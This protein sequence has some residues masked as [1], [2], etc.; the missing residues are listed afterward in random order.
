M[1]IPGNNSSSRA[2]NSNAGSAGLKS[3]RTR[4]RQTNGV[5]EIVAEP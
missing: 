5:V 2:G 1:T 4:S 3:I